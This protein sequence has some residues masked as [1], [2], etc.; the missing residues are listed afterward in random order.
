MNL[1]TIFLTGLFTGGLTCLAVQGGLLATTIAQRESQK[2][3][4]DLKRTGHAFP[5]L[6]F[7]VAKLVAYTIL[8]F[9]LGSL[10]SVLQLSLKTTVIL[11]IGVG[12]FMIGTALAILDVHPIFR[13]FIIQPPR[14]LTRII[15]RESKSKDLFAPA[16][17]GAFTIFIPCGTTQAMM[18]LAI[19][20]GNAILG[21]TILFVFVLGTSPVFF[22]LGYFAT[23]MG[24]FFSGKFMKAAALAIIMLAIFNINSA[25]ALSGSDLTLE[26]LGNKVYCSM[27]AFCDKDHVAGLVAPPVSEATITINSKGYVPNRLSIA[28]GSQVT[29]H[30]KNDGGN[31][32]QQSF[33]IPKL[34]LSKVVPNGNQAT[35]QFT[36]PSEAGTIPFMC[37]MNMY[38]G[39]IEVI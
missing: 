2:L 26:N 18:A 29:L 16:I 23:R 12:I 14:F 39:E 22:T 7:L 19:A 34:G 13:Y 20:S 17:L 33:V 9:L 35:L 11:Q 3:E 28:R 8:G 32:C 25:V 24:D 31:G 21:A 30:L 27:I 36:A 5:I 37:G 6:S 4:G 15:R 10:G 38:R 1:W